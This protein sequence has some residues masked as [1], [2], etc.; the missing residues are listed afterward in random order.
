[1]GQDGRAGA[2][3][4]QRQPGARRAGSSARAAPGRVE[5]GG[6]RPAGIGGNA[7]AALPEHAQSARGGKAPAEP[8]SSV[9]C[10]P[11]TLSGP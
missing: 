9:D 1:M 2:H 7:R 5:P 3:S 8:A 4:R 11:A 6:E 10:R